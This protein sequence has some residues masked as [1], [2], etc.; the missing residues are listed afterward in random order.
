M[1]REEIVVVADLVEAAVGAVFL[2]VLVLVVV[3]GVG[4]QPG[5]APGRGEVPGQERGDNCEQGAPVPGG[6][7]ELK[8]LQRLPL[9]LHAAPP[10]H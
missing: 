7:A 3:V 2:V 10:T 9:P 4:R 6:L 5:R 8:Y 1:E